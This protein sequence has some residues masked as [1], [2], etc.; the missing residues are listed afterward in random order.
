MDGAGFPP[1]FWESGGNERHQRYDAECQFYELCDLTSGRA[2]PIINPVPISSGIAPLAFPADYFSPTVTSIDPSGFFTHPEPSLHPDFFP[3]QPELS[4]PTVWDSASAFS[5]L[6]ASTQQPSRP[7]MQWDD[8][9]SS[10]QP[11]Q[12]RPPST[13]S[14]EED[15]FGDSYAID[16]LLAQSVSDS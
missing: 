11:P 3:H 9:V 4:A 16:L 8:P 7:M 5:W 2:P 1:Y 13:G 10:F 12:A 14:S 15:I 6:P